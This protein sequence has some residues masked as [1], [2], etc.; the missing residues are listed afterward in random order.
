MA[1]GEFTEERS[2]GRC[3]RWTKKTCDDCRLRE[4]GKDDCNKGKKSPGLDAALSLVCQPSA[5][6]GMD[7]PMGLS[8][9]TK[10]QD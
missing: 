4:V 3:R 10:S 9:P 5:V 7:Y 2:R 6:E 8:C 1:S